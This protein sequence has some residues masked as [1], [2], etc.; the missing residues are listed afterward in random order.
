VLYPDK[1]KSSMKILIIED[2]KITLKTLQNSIES[3]GHTVHTAESGE[4]AL[5]AIENSKFDLIISD[6]MMPGIS[7][8]SLVNVLRSVN[9]YR[10]PIIMISALHNKSLLDAAFEAG[11]N[12]FIAKPF[13][14][15]DLKEKLQ[16]YDNKI[17]K[18]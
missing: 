6:I 14:I 8:L 11:A 9:L 13:A 2:D 1:Q 12:D 10:S 3:L 18:E 4:E 16:K 5:K 7:G 15:E 17:S